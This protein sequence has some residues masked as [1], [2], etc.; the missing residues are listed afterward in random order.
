MA[1]GVL[2]MLYTDITLQALR[3]VVGVPLL[4]FSL[5]ELLGNVLRNLRQRRKLLSSSLGM[6]TLF[7]ISAI[8][9]ASAD[10]TLMLLPRLFGLWALFNALVCAITYY[11]SLQSREPRAWLQITLFLLHFTCAALLFFSDPFR[12]LSEI[13]VATASYAVFYGLTLFVDF[14]D[15]IFPD[16]HELP[17]RRLRVAP[18]V[19]ITSFMPHRVLKQLASLERGDAQPGERILSERKEGAPEPGVEVL[20]HVSDRGPGVYGHMDLFFDGKILSYGAYDE[21]AWGMGGGLGDGVF[22]ELYDKLR[23]I[24]FCQWYSGKTIFG[25][26]VKLT[27]EQRKAMR[28]WI[29]ETREQMIDWQPEAEAKKGTPEGETAQDYASML[30]RVTSAKF[31]KFRIGSRFRNYF[32][33]STNCAYFADSL[34]GAGG[35]PVVKMGGILGPGAFYDFL[36]REYDLP[37]GICV[38]KTIYRNKSNRRI[39]E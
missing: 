8:V 32:S 33:V 2:E 1:L 13:K 4:I 3:Y 22:F 24:R 7:V 21:A 20:V 34:L 25:F 17:R 16:R 18:P 19:F 10:L 23:Y 38:E 39:P 28:R 9:V 37:D 14:L 31:H 29:G 36:S 6:L 12:Y 27:D 11:Q 30:W 5:L 15:G 35:T 26:G